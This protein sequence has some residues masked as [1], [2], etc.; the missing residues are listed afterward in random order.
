MGAHVLK[1]NKRLAF[2]PKPANIDVSRSTAQKL[3]LMP[4]SSYN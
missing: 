4:A 2:A 1:L 3:A